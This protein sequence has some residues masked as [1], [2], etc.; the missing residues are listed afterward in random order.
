MHPQKKAETKKYTFK[1]ELP[2]IARLM[3]PV[4]SGI[5]ACAKA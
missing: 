4:N 1:C 2:H 3:V 5:G